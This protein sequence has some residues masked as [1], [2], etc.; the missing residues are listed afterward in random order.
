MHIYIYMHVCVF[1]D[2]CDLYRIKEISI[3]RVQRKATQTGGNKVM[4]IVQIANLKR[5]DAAGSINW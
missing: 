2:S 1:N 4:Q 3:E 5:R